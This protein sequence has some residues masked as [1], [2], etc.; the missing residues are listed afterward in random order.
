MVVVEV[1]WWF[2]LQCPS[3]PKLHK[4]VVEVRDF[5]R[6]CEVYGSGLM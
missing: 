1:L 2:S 4:V 6:S 3:V 5:I